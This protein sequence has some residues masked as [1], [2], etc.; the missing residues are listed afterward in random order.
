[1]MQT[2]GSAP[3][4]LA[5]LGESIGKA[6]LEKA[7]QADLEEVFLRNPARR[8]HVLSDEWVRHS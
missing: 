1:M 2:N 4:N 8:H 7:G 6:D 5:P 3:S